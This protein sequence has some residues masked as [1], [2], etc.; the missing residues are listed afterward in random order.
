MISKIKFFIITVALLISNS[1]MSN[2][3]T[4][5]VPY[6][7]GGSIDQ[8]MQRLTPALS[9]Q[10]YTLNVEFLRSCPKSINLVS[11]R[12]NTFMTMTSVDFDPKNP[13]ARCVMDQD[14]DNIR[15]WS[16]I[17]SSP[18]YLCSS[19]TKKLSLS[20]LSSKEKRVGVVVA[21]ESQIYLDYVLRH[22]SFVHSIKPIPYR[23]GG[24]MLIATRTGDVDLWFGS[25]QIRAFDPSDIVCFGSSVRNDPR[26]IP[27]IG[28]LINRHAQV[29]LPSLEIGILLFAKS[30]NITDDVANAM[31]TA[32]N[33]PEFL[34]YVHEHQMMLIKSDPEQLYQDLLIFRQQIRLMEKIN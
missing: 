16:G 23:G 22:A 2:T 27:F 4:V 9:R 17:A 32:L 19:P 26:G 30:G 7:P 10:G 33:S 1:A 11:V 8:V 25:S 24:D 18:F 5:A 20:D 34:D 6:G 29:E 21:P 31:K 15:I 14:Q 12:K 13:N 3:I 28:E